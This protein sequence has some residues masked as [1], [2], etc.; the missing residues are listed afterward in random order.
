MEETESGGCQQQDENETEKF[1][2]KKPGVLEK[3][4]LK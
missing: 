2:D 1:D 3:G 4:M